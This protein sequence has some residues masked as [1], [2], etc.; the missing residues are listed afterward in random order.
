M[1]SIADTIWEIDDYLWYIPFVLIIALGLYSTIRFKGIQF[2]KLKEMFRITFSK[3]KGEKNESGITP[4]HVFCVSM[5]NRV[6]IGNIAG[7]V[8]AIL[9]GGPGAIFWMWVFAALGGATSF[10]EST[11]GQLFKSRGHDGI[12]KG[13]P[14]YNISK[15]LQWKK[16]GVVVA[17]LMILMYIVGYISS[18]VTAI[19]EA[20]CGAFQFENNSLILAI[21]MTVIAGIVAIGGFKGV[22]KASAYIVPFM[23]LGWF[24]LCIV[25]IVMNFSN[26]GNAFAMIFGYAFNPPAFVGGLAGSL[27]V[28]MRRG[29]WSNEAGI[30]TITNVSSM[31]DVDHPAQQGLSQSLG[32]LF[33]TII[34]TLTAFVVLTFGGFDAT[35]QITDD[36]MPYLQSIFEGA[37]GSIAPTLVFIFVFLFAI[38]CFMGDFVIGENNLRFITE[39]KKAKIGIIV[40][41]MVVVFISCFWASDTAFAVLDVLLAI[42]G[43]IN[44]IAIF[45]LFN[46]AVEVYKDYREQKSKGIEEPK[47]HKDALSDDTGVTEWD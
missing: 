31:A 27:I 12:S 5:G 35:I 1:S 23:A 14:A 15:G 38:T 44:C 26:L 3:T 20:F 39:S 30:G 28:G 25:V 11:I 40:L 6:G 45:K 2:T 22:A 24:A 43:V 47:F 41:V 10:V 42:C 33:D 4:F 29:I 8:T 46:R 32:V 9:T 37:I 36:S 13:G 21:V 16:L 7:P 18:E 17:F 19:S 34:C